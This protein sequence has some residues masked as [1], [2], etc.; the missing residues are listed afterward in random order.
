MGYGFI[1]EVMCVI[2]GI[3]TGV[4]ASQHFFLKPAVGICTALITLGLYSNWSYYACKKD[5]AA[6]KLRGMSFDAL[7]PVKMAVF[8]PLPS[9]I[10]LAALYMM[11]AGLI[12]DNFGLYLFFNI[13]IKP[14]V[15]MFAE[16]PPP[17]D[18]VPAAGMAGITFLVMLQPAAIAAVYLLTYYDVDVYK[19]I[20]FKKNK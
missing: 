20:F 15:D 7:V 17:I 18:R 4:P 1:A 5:K 3:A 9:Y 10:A 11:K 16:Q 8:A 6:I 19:R 12:S 13:W 2:V 14:F